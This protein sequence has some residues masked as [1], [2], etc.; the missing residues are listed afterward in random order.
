[1]SKLYTGGCLCGEIRYQIT[2][3]PI[4]A[5][6]C[7]CAECQKVASSAFG[8][9]VR[10][11][12]KDFNITQ[13]KP[14]SIKTLADSGRTKYGYFCQ[15]CGTRIYGEPSSS[16]FVVVKAGTLDD[17]NWFKPIAHIWTRSA[18]NWF[19]FSDKLKKFEQAPEDIDELSRLWAEVSN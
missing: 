12:A 13:G 18:Q 19:P 16:T 14:K 15:E 17:P 1:M 11:D 8:M 6:N 2:E 5:Y 4:T 10:I 3:N 7:H 9:S